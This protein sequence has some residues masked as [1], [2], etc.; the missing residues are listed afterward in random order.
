MR[1]GIWPLAKDHEDVNAMSRLKAT[2]EDVRHAYRLLLGREPDEGGFRTYCDILRQECLEPERIARLLMNSTEFR[3]RH[4]VLTMMDV[5][6]PPDEGVFTLT[7]QACTQAQLE[8][9]VFRHR[10]AALKERPG[11]LHRKLWEWCFIA[12]A[13][14]ERGMLERGLR[15]L[16]SAVGSEPLSALFAITWNPSISSGGFAFGQIRR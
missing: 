11:W 12:Q 4:G 15:G 5:G 2:Q 13:L 14:F 16:G 9:P 10:A 8:S 6:R 3:E 1:L 7:S